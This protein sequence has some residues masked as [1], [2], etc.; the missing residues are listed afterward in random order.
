VVSGRGP[1][2]IDENHSRL[3]NYIGLQIDEIE[4]YI[5]CAGPNS[6]TITKSTFEITRTKA[7]QKRNAQTD[8]EW[9][10]SSSQVRLR[11]NYYNFKTESKQD[12]FDDCVSNNKCIAAT[13]YHDRNVCFYYDSTFSWDYDDKNEGLESIIYSGFT[14]RDPNKKLGKSF[15]N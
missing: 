15:F 1:C 13:F 2:V 6:V 11:N 7:I 4:F 10:P 8:I 5:Q 9:F 14:L 3:D 12:C